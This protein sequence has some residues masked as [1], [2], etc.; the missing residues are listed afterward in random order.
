MRPSYLFALLG[1][2]LL[3]GAG[4]W[5]HFAPHTGADAPL[6][7]AERKEAV[8]SP[9]SEFLNAS[10]S[11][12]FYKSKLQRAPN[13]VKSYLALSQLYLQQA[14]A[15]A[16]EV[17]YVPLAQA[18]LQEALRRSPDDFHARALE[19]SLF[20]T[21][22]RF[23]DAEAAVRRLMTQYPDNAFLTGVLVDALVE[24]GRYDEAAA[25]SD[26]MQAIRPDIG[27]YSRVSYL[28]EL[29]GDTPGAIAAMRYAADA[30]MSGHEDRAWALYHLGL[31]YLGHGETQKADVLFHGI[32]D[33]RPGFWRALLGLARIKL[34]EGQTAVATDLYQQAYDEAP[35]HEAM[36]GLLEA[37]TVAGNTAGQER[38]KTQLRRAFADAKGM[39]ER[40]DM[41][42]A[43]F[44]ADHDLDLDRALRQ[45]MSEVQR[46]PGHLHAN[47]TAAWALFKNGKAREAVP[48]IQKALRLNTGDAM[49]EY[50]A[51]RIYE[52]A[53][54]A[55]Q[56]EAMYRAALAHRVEVESPSTAGWIRTHL[57][58]TA[59]ASAAT[60]S[61]PKP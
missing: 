48:Y 26:R 59:P 44:L 58:S 25:A 13:D 54:N 16:D 10:A 42:E 61:A 38:I 3:L 43:D 60:A 50:R 18:A 22:H 35:S 20:A 37:Y 53:G 23:E 45:A 7:E 46:R 15:T 56:A 21:L 9:S 49:A 34:M 2:A 30:G 28:R 40:A 5:L 14:H 36:E 8:L 39:G 47:E 51:A 17:R 4:L 33:E 52:A 41:E 29:H 6:T 11:I 19:A 1:G 55:A 31:L 32:L 57:G 12:N 27:S 24:L